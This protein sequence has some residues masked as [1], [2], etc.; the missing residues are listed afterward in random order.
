MSRDTVLVTGAAGFI[1]SHLVDRLAERFQVVAVDNLQT[2]DARNLAPAREAVRFVKLD[3]NDRPGIKFLFSKNNFR[4]VFHY[5]ATVGVEFTLAQPLKVLD[6]IDGARNLLELARLAGVE[7]V[8][9]ASSSEVYGEPVDAVQHEDRT[10]L[11]SR[12]PY[13]VVKNL[14]E[15]YLRSYRS[16]YGLRYT[17]FL[18]FNTFGPRQSDAFVMTRF[19]RQ[20]LAGEPLTV[21]GDG[22]QSRKLNYVGNK[23]AAVPAA[24]D[25]PA[26]IDQVINIGAG[27]EISIQSLAE[28]VITTVGSLSTIVHLPA[29]TEGDMTRRQLDTGRLRQMLGDLPWVE[30]DD[31]LARTVDWFRQRG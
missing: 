26:S 18:I 13:A 25:T 16:E 23:V 20:V 5:A 28:R 24:I 30:F 7:R 12:L 11:N 3:V 8:F 10:P 2:G 29:R 4:F 22:R 21:N 17:I 27:Y 19:I 6:D 14:I 15:A 1:G 9:Y 31:G